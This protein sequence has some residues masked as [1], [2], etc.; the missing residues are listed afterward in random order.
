MD[1]A[2]EPAQLLAWAASHD[3]RD[4]ERL[5]DAVVA[6]HDEAAGTRPSAAIN[7]LIGDIFLRLAQDAEH[8]IRRRL[9]Q[10]LADADWA[11]PALVNMLAREE[12][13]IARP[14]I[15][16]SPVLQ[17]SDL[18][19]LLVQSTIEHQIAVARRGQLS[20]TVVEAILG[21]DEPAVLTALACNETADI[22][23]LG[24]SRLVE[25]S[26]R[27]AALRSPL[28]R[29]PRLSS[30]MALRLYIWVG[31][32]MR[33]A[34]IDRFQLDPAMLDAALS[35]SVMDV[36]VRPGGSDADQA[37]QETRLVGKLHEAGELRPGYL[38]KALREER[39]QLFIEGLAAL[40]GFDAAHIRLALNSDRPE[41][42]ALACAA[43]GIDRGVFPTILDAVRSLN[44]GRPSGGQDGAR[45]AA[46][47]FGPFAPDIAGMAFR[48]TI[49]SAV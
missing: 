48:Q 8:D 4:R 27:M 26:R 39:L 41:L 37:M 40:G 20:A 28:S 15:A 25:T 29:H 14:L 35:E 6:M 30:G 34:L 16:Q 10:R 11:P 21:Q 18:I 46:G 33:T 24:M 9:S 43:V 17:D 22:S 47:A 19:R 7:S 31:Q 12:I 45:R 5:I 38:M 23:P 44:G 2:A 1:L 42:L 3:V 13:E 32:S 49:A 36:H